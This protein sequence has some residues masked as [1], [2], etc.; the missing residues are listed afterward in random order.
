MIDADS[1]PA[2]DSFGVPARVLNLSDEFYGA[3]GRVAALGAIVELR[4]S[5]IV[6]LWSGDQGLAGKN[7]SQVAD[8]FKKLGERREIPEGLRMAF[9]GARAAMSERNE[10]LHSLWPREDAGWRNRREGVIATTYVD[11]DGV[12]EVIGRLVDASDAL[13][14]YLHSPG[15]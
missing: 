5:D 9:D 4:L 14:H 10:L 11:V 13:G 2:T 8:S 7:V 1:G 6:V 3:L 15:E 12:I